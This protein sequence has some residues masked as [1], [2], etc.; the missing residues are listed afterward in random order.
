MRP[1][2]SSDP[3]QR[4]RER[5]ALGHVKI[6]EDLLRQPWNEEEPKQAEA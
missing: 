1:A 6:L 5:T 3:M 2:S 4:T